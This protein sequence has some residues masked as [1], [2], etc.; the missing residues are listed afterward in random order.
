[1]IQTSPRYFIRPAIQ[2]SMNEI[3][4]LIIQEANNEYMKNRHQ[5][6]GDD[7]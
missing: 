5:T 3:G 2:E 4:K 1:M 7:I 6:D